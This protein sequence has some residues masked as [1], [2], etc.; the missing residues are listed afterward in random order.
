[1][2]VLAIDFVLSGVK[3]VRE[4]DRLIRHIALVVTDN[5]FVGG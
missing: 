4:G 1:V 2:A 5:Y 3:F